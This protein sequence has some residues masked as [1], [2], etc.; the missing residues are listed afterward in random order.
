[1]TAFLADPPSNPSKNSTRPVVTFG[2][3]AISFWA[4]KYALGND[5]GVL[6]T[7]R[8]KLTPDA[9]KATPYMG[10]NHPIRAVYNTC[11]SSPSIITMEI[12]DLTTACFVKRRKNGA[13][14]ISK[15]PV[16]RTEQAGT[17]WA[18]G[19]ARCPPCTRCLR[20]LHSGA[21][22]GGS[23]TLGCH[24]EPLERQTQRVRYERRRGP[25]V[26]WSTSRRP[27]A[28][29]MTAMTT[30]PHK[31]VSTPAPAT[32]E[33]PAAAHGPQR[34]AHQPNTVVAPLAAHEAMAGSV[35]LF[36][37][38]QSGATPILQALQG[39]RSSVDLSVYECAHPE[40]EAALTAAARRGVTVRVMLEPKPVGQAGAYASA[41]QKLSAPGLT[42]KPTPP[43]FDSGHDV[44]H[45]KFMIIDRQKL[46][47]GTGNLTGSGLGGDGKRT[48][49]DFWIEDTRPQSV[50]EA[51]S[52]FNADWNREPSNA[53]QPFP[54]LVVTPNNAR[55]SLEKLI[56]GAHTRLYVY[57]QEFLDPSII[58]LLI[59]AKKRKVDV[60]VLAAHPLP[61]EADKNQPALQQFTSAGIPAKEL[62][63]YY[64]HAK[65]IIADDQ[66][67]VGSQNFSTAALQS[68]RELGGILD[69]P[70]IVQ[71]L[72]QTF[73]GDFASTS[74]ALPHVSS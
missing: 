35:Q 60:R 43:Q 39:A 19:H 54:H 12:Q 59:A 46:L 44:D 34:N 15:T 17:W 6:K 73:Q 1:M 30:T 63:R 74:C 23:S 25:S 49:R 16:P 53:T 20:G 27:A 61:G 7:G 28:G 69:A 70:E 42:L 38:P 58:A 21:A 29:R 3:E 10:A 52:L 14:R 64:L 57:N 9:T 51:E 4:D 68:N 47:F 48:N 36:P 8:V 67:F 33:H 32:R 50:S 37:M 2:A 71:Q 13:T 65:V 31:D 41:Q 55:D 26:S 72:V 40:V 24:E 66:A 22:L 5:Y 62:T 45:A 18:S 56:T 11:K